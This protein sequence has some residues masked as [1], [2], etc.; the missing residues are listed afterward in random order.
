MTSRFNFL[1]CGNDM[2]QAEIAKSLFNTG[3]NTATLKKPSEIK[4]WLDKYIINQ[5]NA[6]NTISTLLYEHQKQVQYNSN[7]DNGQDALDRT[8]MFCIGATGKFTA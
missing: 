1:V 4:A 5:E 7:L 2:R 6:K 8:N 3:Y